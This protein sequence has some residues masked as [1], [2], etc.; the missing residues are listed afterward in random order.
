MTFRYLGTFRL[1]LAALVVF[2][3][4]GFNLGDG[5]TH[6]LASHWLPGTPAVLVFLA[7]SGFVMAEISPQVTLSWSDPE[8]SSLTAYSNLAALLAGAQCADHFAYLPARRNGPFGRGAVGFSIFRRKL[9]PLTSC[10]FGRL[11]GPSN[12]A[13]PMTSWLSSGRC[14]TKPYFILPCSRRSPQ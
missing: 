13:Y 8:H 6:E 1:F 3:H 5:L 4:V 7:I 11:H 2:H 10:M 9:A 12:T 14:V